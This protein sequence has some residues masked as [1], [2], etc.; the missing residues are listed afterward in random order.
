MKTRATCLGAALCLAILP[1]FAEEPPPRKSDDRPVT[2]LVLGGGGAKGAAHIGVLQ[3]LEA[4]NIA[5][6]FIVGTSMG[7]IVGGLYAS[8]MPPGR[9]AWEIEQLDWQA[10]FRDQPARELRSFQRKLDDRDFHAD[11]DIGL[12]AEG[13]RLP[14]GVLQGQ[15]A[16]QQLQ[17]LTVRAEGIEH[18]DHLPIPFRAVA[19]D[20]L[21]GEAVVLERGDLA[22]A[23]RASMSIPGLFAPVD[24]DNRLLIDGGIAANT[25]I[26]IARAMGAD[27]LIVV[28]VG[29]EPMER[30]RI[31]D[32]LGVTEQSLRL[33]SQQQSREQLARLRPSDVLIR[34]EIDD[35]AMMDFERAIEAVDIGVAAARDADDALAPLGLPA[36]EYVEW[37]A[38]VRRTPPL[39]PVVDALRIDN[40]S[41]LDDRYIRSRIR[42]PI[43]EPLDREALRHD[44]AVLHGTGYFDRVSH[45]WDHGPEGESTL[46]VEAIERERGRVFLRVGLELE[47]DFAG[48]SNY[49]AAVGLYA[50]MI[51]RWGGEWRLDLRLGDRPGAST[52][53]WQPLGATSDWFIAPRARVEREQLPLMD[54]DGETF[55]RI[56]ITRREA[57]LDAG[58]D[59]GTSARLRA[60]LTRGEVEISG[61]EGFA[62]RPGGTSDTGTASLGFTWDDLDRIDFPRRGTNAGIDYTRHHPDLGADDDFDQASL[63]LRTVRSVG[64]FT[65]GL[66]GS[67]G[68]TLS[69]DEAPVYALFP[70]GGLFHLS[71]LRRN[72]RVGSHFA[73][74]GVMFRRS[75]GAT[76]TLVGMPFHAGVTVEAGNVWEERR[77]IDLDDALG[78]GSV[79]AGTDTV[80]GPLYLG[81]GRAQGSRTTGYFYLGRFF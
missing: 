19:S 69:D 64:R 74:A 79:F 66:F 29:A 13:V 40:R 70:L 38:R 17:T 51:N 24:I 56:R 9:I 11:F 16:M 26:E 77:D 33:L 37:L 23:M 68:V 34:P 31:R 52:E 8:G 63:S 71:G 59:F 1:A 35:M 50:P 58:R 6:D 15:Q 75:F 30:E 25:P 65:G 76:D 47:E 60:G 21:T 4:H 53:L 55:A 41:P 32:A 10:V 61:R 72:E 36:I 22:L 46:V 81:I 49:N 27:V 39:P 54:A 5:V 2:G 80:F 28:D 45:R 67:A 14:L 12:T 3:I 18:F 73:H 20:L 62:E 43:G 44:L 42:Q 78:G 48:E 7:A 57:G